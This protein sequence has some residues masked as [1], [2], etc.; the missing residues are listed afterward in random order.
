V[1]QRTERCLAD[2]D[3]TQQ[4]VLVLDTNESAVSRQ[5]PGSSLMSINKHQIKGRIRA[6]GGKVQEVT[7]KLIGSN[8]QQAR[9]IAKRVR[10]EI[11]SKYGDAKQ[12]LEN[13]QKG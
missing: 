13:L 10:G 1:R 11:Q 4:S 6:A 5:L 9:G 8:E 2:G 12:N 3:D 7:G